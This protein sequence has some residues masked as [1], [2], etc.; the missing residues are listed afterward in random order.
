MPSPGDPDKLVP[1]LDTL[2]QLASKPGSK[3]WFDKERGLFSIQE[4]GLRQ[5]LKR[6]FT[7][8]SV[9]SEELFGSPIRDLFAAAA[10]A[11]F[12][13]RHQQDSLNL[14]A[15]RDNAVK[16]LKALRDNTYANDQT[17]KN[18]LAA[19]IEDAELGPKK[20]PDAMIRLRERYHGYLRYG[21]A[22]VMF[23]PES[24]GGVCY[25]FVLYWA[26][27][28]RRGKI[29]FG[30]S[31]YGEI[32]AYSGSNVPLTLDFMHKVRISNKVDTTI[33]P[34][35]EEMR[36][37]QRSTWATAVMNAVRTEPFS[38]KYGDLFIVA[39]TDADK[40]IPDTVR[41]SE[42]M[43]EV[44]NVARKGAPQLRGAKVRGH[45]LTGCC[46]KRM[47]LWRNLGS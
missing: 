27:R 2:A 42:V 10:T 37:Y 43:N 21:F 24:N 31:K 19:V 14:R 44:L 11:L 20:D 46:S 12:D 7:K 17:K 25:S 30:M 23:L 5:G 29:E 38:R 47:T 35:Q 8:Q 22:Q 32:K 15:L 3:L 4:K 33:R 39:C 40:T 6:S 18:A 1:N 34:L 26:E 28:I 13:G 45:I 36:A 9:T 41:G 16:G